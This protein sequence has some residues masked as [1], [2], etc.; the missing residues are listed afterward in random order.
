MRE[1]SASTVKPAMRWL[2]SWVRLACGNRSALL[3][4]DCRSC[5]MAASSLFLLRR[6]QIR[7]ISHRTAM[8]SDHRDQILIVNLFLAISQVGELGV[9]FLELIQ[10]HVATQRLE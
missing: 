4:P 7:R 3:M 6:H 5:S 1:L 10:G 2:I 9:E 8:G